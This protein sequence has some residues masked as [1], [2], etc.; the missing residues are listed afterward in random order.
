MMKL[1]KYKKN[2]KISLFDCVNMIIMLL[3][4][5]VFILPFWLMLT[6]SLSDEMALTL[7]GLKLWFQGFT[8]EAYVELFSNSSLVNS[9]G[10]TLFVS[11][12]T[13]IL[14]ALVCTGAAYVLSKKTLAG[15][16]FL[17]WYFMIPIFFSGGSVPV[18]LVIR[19]IGLYDTIWALILPNVA[20]ILN[21]VLVRNYFYGLPDSLHEAAEI[22]GANELQ[23]L[24]RIYFPLAMPMTFTIGL[25][26]FVGKWNSWLDSMMYL[27]VKNEKLWMTQYVLRRML[28]DNPQ[29]PSST[30]VKNAAIV[31][32][33]LPLILLAP[34]LHKYF[35]KGVTAGSVKG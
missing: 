32:V 27:G 22:D 34:V 28:E 25:M 16:K 2:K 21:I 8:I 23:K 4:A 15:R 24:I 10:V 14:S 35:A 26:A 30:S 13:A 9:L 7:N 1:R 33:V 11:F 18:Y 5:V 31:V 12:A 20:N 19:N 29:E 6:A 17:S 3:L